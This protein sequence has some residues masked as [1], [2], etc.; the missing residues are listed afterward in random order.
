MSGFSLVPPEPKRTVDSPS[1]TSRVFFLRAV[2]PNH[3]D[4]SG[5]KIPEKQGFSM[6][7]DKKMLEIQGFVIGLRH[8]SLVIR[9]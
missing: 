6:P 9:Q 4:S 3:F 5:K 8:W 7:V 1:T 2:F